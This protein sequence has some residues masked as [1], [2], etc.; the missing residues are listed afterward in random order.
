MYRKPDASGAEEA[1]EQAAEESKAGSNETWETE[2][3]RTTETTAATAGQN[4]ESRP[5]ARWTEGGGISAWK[6]RAG[7]CV[8]ALFRADWFMSK[9][10]SRLPNLGYLGH[11]VKSRG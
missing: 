11:E 6:T 5:G 2:T 10:T 1:A 7:E 8:R 4:Q 3:G 9:L